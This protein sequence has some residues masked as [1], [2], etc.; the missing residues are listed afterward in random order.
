MGIAAPVIEQEMADWVAL[1]GGNSGIVGDANHSFGF[2]VAAD[3]LPAS[4]YSR[5]RDPNGSDGPYVNWDYACAGDFSHRG[6]PALRAMHANV[7]ARL[8][9]GE[10]PMICE[11]IGQPVAGQPVVYWA[12]WNGTGALQRYTGSGHDH[13]SHISWYRSTVDQRAYLWTEDGMAS[14]TWDYGIAA[15][16][17]LDDGSTVP[18]PTQPTL[19]AGVMLSS[20]NAAAWEALDRL[21]RVDKALVALAEQLQVLTDQIAA[22]PPGGASADQVAD[23]LA[24]RLRQ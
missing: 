17:I 16:E 10:L 6:D 1:G 21:D 18:H 23:E 2:H 12:R 24:E 7:L 13:W 20:T 15:A 5:T 22:T 19:P 9:R 4:D 14:Q 3:E 8:L 11:F